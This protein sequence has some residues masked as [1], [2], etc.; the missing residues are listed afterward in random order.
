MRKP[1]VAELALESQHLTPNL[2]LL[3]V[4]P[5]QQGTESGGKAAWVPFDKHI[6]LAT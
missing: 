3:S 6:M 1:G 4:E 5:E 2:L